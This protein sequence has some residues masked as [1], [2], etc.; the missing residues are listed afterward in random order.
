MAETETDTGSGCPGPLRLMDEADR[1]ACSSPG[2]A[3]PAAEVEQGSPGVR[4]DLPWDYTL[5]PT[6]VRILASM[7]MAAMQSRDRPPEAA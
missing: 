2:I 6:S 3:S 4:V 1:G 7:L 5:P